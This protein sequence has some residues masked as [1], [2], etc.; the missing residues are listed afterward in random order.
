MDML[1][2]PS[3]KTPESKLTHWPDQPAVRGQT[4]GV[5]DPIH[6]GHQLVV[7]SHDTWVDFGTVHEAMRRKVEQQDKTLVA[8]QVAKEALVAQL[9]QTQ[10]RLDA[11][12]QAEKRRRRASFGLITDKQEN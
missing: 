7:M 10:D 2:P 6:A 3:A 4:Y 11:L 8:L 5:N 9:A 12:R 1:S